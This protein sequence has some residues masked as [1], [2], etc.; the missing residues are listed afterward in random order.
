VPGFLCALEKFAKLIDS[1][2]IQLGFLYR[3]LIVNELEDV[4]S[5]INTSS[6]PISRQ[7]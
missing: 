3:L 6:Q 5:I 2:R 7:F 4:I 1:L